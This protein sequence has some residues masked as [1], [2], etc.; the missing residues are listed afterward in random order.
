MS[1]KHPTALG[2]HIFLTYDLDK[3]DPVSV[4]GWLDMSAEN[5]LSGSGQVK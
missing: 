5:E 2:S 1:G 4:N 3:V